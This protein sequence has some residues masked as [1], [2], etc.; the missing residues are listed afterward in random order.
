M[1]C[2]NKRQ[3]TYLKEL[4]IGNHPLEEDPDTPDSTSSTST[5]SHDNPNCGDVATSPPLLLTDGTEDGA[6]L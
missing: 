2:R 5:G 3:L 4:I 1:E 6:K